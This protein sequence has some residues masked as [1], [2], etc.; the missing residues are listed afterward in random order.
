VRGPPQDVLP[1]LFR[2]WGVSRLTYEYDTEPYSRRRDQAVGALA[3]DHGV[4]VVYR[5][6]HTLHNIDRSV[7]HRRTPS[8]RPV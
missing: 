3:R 2:E 5:I 8:L 6:S 4:E 1:G 7:N